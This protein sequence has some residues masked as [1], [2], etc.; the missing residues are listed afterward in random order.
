[1]FSESEIFLG[2]RFFEKSQSAAAG[3]CE[4]TNQELVV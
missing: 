1:M 3:S 2:S 4:T